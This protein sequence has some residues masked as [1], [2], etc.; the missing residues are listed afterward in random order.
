MSKHGYP[1]LIGAGFYN[2]QLSQSALGSKTPLQPM[3]DWH[4]RK[5]KL[6]TNQP[7]HLAG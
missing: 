3:K 2:Q 5:P 4:N 6:Y 1:R 7:N